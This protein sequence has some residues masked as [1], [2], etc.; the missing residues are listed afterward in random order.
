VVITQVQPINVVFAIPEVSLSQVLQAS[1]TNKQ[2]K[3]EAWDRDNRNKLTDGTLLA[4]DNQLNTSTGTISL[5]AKF[6]NDK[7]ELFPNQF[8]NVHL[9]LGAKTDAIIVPTIAVQLG[10]VGSYVYTVN[11]DQTVSIS[12]VKVGA[13]SGDNS[14]IEEGLE[15]GQKVVID[16]LDKLRDGAKVK[17]IDRA[18]QASASAAEQASKPQKKKRDASGGGASPNKGNPS[19]SN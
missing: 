19:A 17:A 10:K 5:K 16:G 9:Q 18:A 3:V 13:A 2:L 8:V 11:E 7:Q 14:I 4:I 15:P 12:K 6:A 1:A